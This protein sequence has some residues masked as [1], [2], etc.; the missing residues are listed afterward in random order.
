MKKPALLVWVSL[1][2]YIVFLTLFS[3][4]SYSLTATNLVLSTNDFF[5]QF[6]TYMWDNFFNN[7]ELLSRVYF[8]LITG[9]FISYFSL[10]TFFF[11]NEAGQ[12]TKKKNWRLLLGFFLLL[13]LPLLL[14]SNAL[15]YD[16]FNY[17][18]N[19]KM[20]AVYGQNPHQVTALTFPDD[21]WIRFMHNTHTTAPYGYGWT[22]LSLIPFYLGFGKFILTWIAFRIFSVVALLALIFIFWL[23]KEKL[24]KYNLL[25][26]IFNPLLLIE[27]ISNIHNDF[28][29]ISSAVASL[30]IINS[31]QDGR[32]NKNLKL[33]I[34]V[35][36]S[37]TLLAMSIFVKLA[38]VVLLPIWLMLLFKKYLKD[39]PRFY[40]MANNWPLL[41]SLAMFAPLLT[42]RSQQ[43]HPWYL[44]WSLAF[45]PFFKKNKVSEIWAHGLI[46]LSISSMYRYLPFLM[47]NNFNGDILLQQKE[48][49]FLPLLLY[50]FFVLMQSLR[51]YKKPG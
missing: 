18:F 2:S 34:K 31:I 8:T 35:T 21:P 10:V 24:N 26:F 16:V 29:M 1:L 36:L 6:Q 19:A 45:I 49:T 28:W 5:W 14:S 27:I 25:L 37:L 33:A 23:Q 44:T 47:N 22:L 3:I 17:I 7:R 43:F 30:L 13:A 41:A 11:K 40:S 46:I 50:F 15:S 39:I 20:V 48:T 4:F 51:S 38:T 9:A 42:L 32:S 12:K